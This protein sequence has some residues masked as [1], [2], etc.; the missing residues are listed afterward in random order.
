MSTVTTVLFGQP[1]RLKWTIEGVVFFMYLIFDIQTME[2]HHPHHH[3]PNK[4][5]K[6]YFLEFSMLFL[7]VTLGFLA[8]N[9]REHITERRREKEFIASIVHD[10]K[11]D[12]ADIRAV[13]KQLLK[14]VHLQDTLIIALPAYRET[15]TTSKKLYNLYFQSATSLNQVDFNRNALNQMLNTGS[16]LL[17]RRQSIVDSIMNYVGFTRAVDLQGTYYKQAFNTAFENSKN[18]FDLSY[19]HFRLKDDLSFS[20][21]FNRDTARFKL[22]DARPAVLKRYT[23]DLIMQQNIC[24]NYLMELK[25]ANNRAIRVIAL[26]KKEYKLDDNDHE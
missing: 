17:V 22:N 18:I 12:T 24:E 13:S 8:E 10:L 11:S 5:L 23:A 14:Q 21:I 9:L 19:V 20:K 4:K 2:V 6:E 1:G 16:T 25:E 26:L 7:A 3:H 15:D